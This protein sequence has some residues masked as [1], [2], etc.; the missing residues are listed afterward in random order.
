MHF[1]KISAVLLLFAS[2]SSVWA[3]RVP[4]KTDQG[5]VALIE[6]SPVYPMKR[7]TWTGECV[8]GYADGA[9]V[10]TSYASNGS[11]GQ[12]YLLMR[13]GLPVGVELQTIGVPGDRPVA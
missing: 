12:S 11:G 1:V 5:C 6:D 8:E 2:I 13:R 10:L 7:L 4:F 3:A 9:G